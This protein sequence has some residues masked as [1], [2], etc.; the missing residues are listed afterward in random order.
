MTLFVALDIIIFAGFSA[1]AV[2]A[3]LVY[4]HDSGSCPSN[5]MRVR[6]PSTA[7]FQNK[8]DKDMNDGVVGIICID[9]TL[10]IT[11]A[12]MILIGRLSLKNILRK[13]RECLITTIATIV[14][15]KEIKHPVKSNNCIYTYHPIMEYTIGERTYRNTYT[16]G[17]NE[18][19]YYSIGD[20]KEICC[21]SNNR[22]IFYL[23]D[24][25]ASKKR[26]KHMIIVGIVILILTA[27]FTVF[28]VL[29][30]R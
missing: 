29:G 16:Y 17:A 23:K 20:K 22:N 13:E 28:C 10:I 1:L 24:D 11:A 3:E 2:V 19:S 14:G 30:G 4:A 5:W 26:A 18:E 21:N 15:I 9:A 8:G 12:I 7:L 6:L 25:T 27:I